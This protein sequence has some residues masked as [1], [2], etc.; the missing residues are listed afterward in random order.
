MPGP[1]QAGTRGSGERVFVPRPTPIFCVGLCYPK[2]TELS[3]LDSGPG[4]GCCLLGIPPNPR[5][6]ILPGISGDRGGQERRKGASFGGLGAWVQV[7]MSSSLLG[8]VTLTKW[9][10]LPEPQSAHLLSGEETC[11]VRL[12]GSHE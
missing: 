5:L 11:L 2:I 12:R 9:L 6:R 7:P 3:G 1:G 4:L 8:C 10:N